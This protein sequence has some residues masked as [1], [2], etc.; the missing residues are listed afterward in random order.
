MTGLQTLTGIKAE[1][2]GLPGIKK[3]CL[4]GYNHVYSEYYA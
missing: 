2:E 3:L 1:G 4:K